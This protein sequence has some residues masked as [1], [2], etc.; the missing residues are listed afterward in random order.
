M[1]DCH[2]DTGTGTPESQTR[3]SGAL[4]S[5]NQ[6][7]RRR[8]ALPTAQFRARRLVHQDGDGASFASQYLEQARREALAGLDAVDHQYSGVDQPLVV[9]AHTEFL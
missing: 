9:P 1:V 2:W 4:H 3:L 8:V 6:R 5:V 7:V